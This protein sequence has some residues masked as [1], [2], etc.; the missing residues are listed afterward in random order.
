MHST[1]RAVLLTLFLSACQGGTPGDVIP[2][3]KMVNLE[4]DMRL[5]EARIQSGNYHSDT[6]PYAYRKLQRFVLEKHGYN[7][8]QYDSSMSWYIRHPDLLEKIY[9]AAL[10]SIN[11]RYSEMRY[12]D[13]FTEK[14]AKP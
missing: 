12:D 6:I 11:K 4:L 5:A 10:D 14:S 7:K 8:V 1:V 9:E 2:L 3:E 13:E